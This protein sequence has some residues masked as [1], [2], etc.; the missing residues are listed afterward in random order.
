MLATMSETTSPTSKPAPSHS[1]RY[2]YLILVAIVVIAG[3]WLF[4]NM[5]ASGGNPFSS[6]PTKQTSSL[7]SGTYPV[8]ARQYYEISFFVPQGATQS[9]IQF[10]FTASGGIGNDIKV[11][12]MTDIDFVNWKNGHSASTLYNSGQ[13]TTDSTTVSLGPGT[14]HIVFDNTYSLLSSKQVQFS[15][16]LTYYI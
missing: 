8:P 4:S 12:V 6:G 3:L 11:Y 15:G 2:L 1:K 13:V 10:T 9:S 5:Q 16:T 7:G 14:Y